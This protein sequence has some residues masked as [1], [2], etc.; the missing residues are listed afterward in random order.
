MDRALQIGNEEGLEAVSLRR[1][2][3][4]L[5]VTPM[6]LYR[7]FRDKQDLVNAM[8]EKVL[9][10]LDIKAGLRPS[11]SWS[12]RL[13]RAMT[14]FKEEMDARPLAMRLSIEYSGEGPREFW[15]MTEDLLAI[16]MGAGFRRRRA[17]VLIRVISNLLSGYLLLVQ[18]GQGLEAQL[19]PRQ[20]ELLR[21]RFEL[22]QLSLPADQFPILVA[23]AR[24][25]AEVWLSHPD[26]WWRD[27]V[28]LLIFGL[29]ATLEK[30][31]R[32]GRTT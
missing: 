7:H 6:A 31:R 11:M 20:V 15:G 24:D 26:R 3:T 30:E 14:T 9:E 4:D 8:T 1:L 21:K 19:G 27:T 5:E 2:A 28:D 18:Q 32:A 12:D 25:M 17:M 16:L 22:V 23:G 13:R 10:G 29:E